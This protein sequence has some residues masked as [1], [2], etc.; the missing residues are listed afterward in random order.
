[1]E[2]ENKV[3]ALKRIAKR[4]SDAGIMIYNFYSTTSTGKMASCVIRTANDR[5]AIKVM[6]KG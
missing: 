1:M 2:T 6:Q 3:G 4:I 5:K